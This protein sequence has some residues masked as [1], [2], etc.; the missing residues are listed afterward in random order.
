MKSPKMILGALVS[1][2]ILFAAAADADT[3]LLENPD[4]S[5]FEGWL[6]GSNVFLGGEWQAFVTD[7][8]T[9]DDRVDPQGE[10]HVFT[11][12]DDGESDR[13]ETF[14]FQE[15]LAGPPDSDWPTEF[16][17]G[18]VIR[19][20]GAASAT[21]QGND[22]SD[23][24]VRAFIKTLGFNEQG[25]QFQLKP[26]YSDFHDIGSSEE[27][28][29]LTVTYPDLAEDDSLQVIQIGLEITT[30]FDGTDMDSGSIFY[31]NLDAFVEGEEGPTWL[32]FNVDEEGFADTGDFMGFVNVINEP[33]IWN[34]NLSKWA[35]VPESTDPEGSGAWMFVNR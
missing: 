26:Q 7:A 13:I 20:T 15:F 19:F 31:K 2:T 5:S 27:S 25:W 17:T 28:F 10:G 12:W 29:D 4:M 24:V 23:M 14:L 16:E 8:Y 1:G 30:E 35:Y 33:W 6:T 22:P 3:P 18:D 9:V 32:G 21:R 11:S 34:V